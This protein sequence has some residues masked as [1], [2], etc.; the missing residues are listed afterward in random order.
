MIFGFNVFGV[1]NEERESLD[2]DTK[3]DFEFCKFIL[4]NYK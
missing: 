4:N 1:I 2:I 3:V